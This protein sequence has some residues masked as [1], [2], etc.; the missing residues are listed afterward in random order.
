MKKNVM[1]RVASIMLVLVLMSSSVISGTFAKYVTSGTSQD[2]ARVAKFGVVV[3]GAANMFNNVYETDDGI[4]SETNS[5][6]SAGAI[7]G[8]VKLVAPGTN[9]NLTDVKI[10]GKPEVA[11]RVTYDATLD[12]GGWNLNGAGYYS[13]IIITVETEKICGLHY[14]SEALF[15]AAV[16]T[17]IANCNKDYAANTDLSTIVSEGPT[18]SWEWAF[19]AEDHNLICPHADANVLNTDAWDT[20]L[21]NQ[22][23][24]YAPAYI[25]LTI[26]TTVTQID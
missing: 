17:A 8:R 14:G 13:P 24:A 10:T 18:V 4:F 3:T 21:G 7:N 15:E 16:K 2:T 6:V 22:A 12:I 11:V 25:D 23:A 19:D 1:M 26:V 5:V 20:I 9:G